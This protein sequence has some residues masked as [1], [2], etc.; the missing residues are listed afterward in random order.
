[1]DYYDIVCDNDGIMLK[2]TDS[3]RADEIKSLGDTGIRSVS[4]VPSP[5]VKIMS[6]TKGASK[7]MESLVG[8]S[9]E[10]IFCTTTVLRFRPERFEL[11]IDRAKITV[12]KRLF[13][14]ADN[15]TSIGLGD[16][17]SVKLSAGSFF[18]SLT[19]KARYVDQPIVITYL[20]RKKAFRAKRIIE[21]LIVASNKGIDLDEIPMDELTEEIIRIGTG[22][23]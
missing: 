5:K 18:G 12:I 3:R 15:I 23:R 14:L 4:D 11:I 16:M 13:L 21:G 19:L 8:R 2:M 22:V 1:M 10:V 17:F 6:R 9:E 7:K 20:S